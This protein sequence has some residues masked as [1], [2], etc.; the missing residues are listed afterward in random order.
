MPILMNKNVQREAIRVA[1]NNC[2]CTD[3]YFHDVQH[4][5]DDPKH[6]GMEI[7]HTTVKMSVTQEYHDAFLNRLTTISDQSDD[8]NKF[9]ID[10]MR[11]GDA[12]E[13]NIFI[14][15]PKPVEKPAT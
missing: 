9:A 4:T 14:G 11:S 10:Q 12:W 15:R 1:C 5:A 3:P 2:K 13:I 8:V 7:H 6:E